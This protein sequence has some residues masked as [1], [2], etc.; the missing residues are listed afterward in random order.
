MRQLFHF[1][2][3]CST[4]SSSH[5]IKFYSQ[6]CIHY[7][8]GVARLFKMRGRQGGLRDEQGCWLG[9]KWQL[10]INLCT[11]CNFIWG[12]EFLSGGSHPP[13]PRY[14]TAL[15]LTLVIPDVTSPAL[16]NL[17]HNTKATMA[18]LIKK[19]WSSP[20]W[21]GNLV[22]FKPLSKHENGDE[23]TKKKINK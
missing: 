16:A 11:K 21:L 13:P 4:S 22:V 2:L 15:Q 14:T 18:S 19:M 20:I 10:S 3:F 7:S 23:N 5:F 8:R 12:A 6:H 17:A 1:S 9:L